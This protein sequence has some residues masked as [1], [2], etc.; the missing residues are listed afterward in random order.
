MK[1]RSHS[2]AETKIDARNKSKFPEATFLTESKSGSVYSLIN[3]NVKCFDKN[4]PLTKFHLFGEFGFFSNDIGYEFGC[5]NNIIR[6]KQQVVYST[7]TSSFRAN[8]AKVSNSP[9][10]LDK[11][12]VDCKDGFINSFQLAKSNIEVYYLASCMHLKQKLGSCESKTTNPANVSWLGIFSDTVSNLD[13]VPLEAPANKALVSF[14]LLVKD[15]KVYYEYKACEVDT[16]VPI[17][18]AAKKIP[19]KNVDNLS[20]KIDKRRRRF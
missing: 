10:L 1:R 15:K 14:K 8:F 17:I 12:D 7:V 11:V 9:K 13:Q 6:P 5:M 16:S 19:G 18:E 3:L 4:G 2:Q 20:V